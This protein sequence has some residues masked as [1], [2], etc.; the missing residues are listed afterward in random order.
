MFKHHAILPPSSLLVSESYSR[1]HVYLNIN[2]ISFYNL[3]HMFK[4]VRSALLD[5]NQHVVNLSCTLQSKVYTM[6][7]SNRKLMHQKMHASFCVFN[8]FNDK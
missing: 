6:F 4:V 2:F 8:F 5:L 3:V 1:V 7:Y